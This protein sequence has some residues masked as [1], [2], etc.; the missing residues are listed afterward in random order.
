[1]RALILGGTGYIGSKLAQ[2]LL[3]KNQVS[4]LVICSRSRALIY[5]GVGRL[6]NEVDFESYL[7]DLDGT[8]FSTVFLLHGNSS[9]ESAGGNSIA[10]LASVLGWKNQVS[11]YLKKLGDGVTVVMASTVSVYGTSMDIKCETSPPAPE[12][13]Y[14]L[15]KWFLERHFLLGRYACTFAVA[16]LANVY[17][18]SFGE[19]SSDR[20]VVTK[21]VKKALNESRIEIYGTGKY[22]RDYVHI[23]DVCSA[24][25]KISQLDRAT[26]SEQPIFNVCSGRSRT[27]KEV[28]SLIGHL[29]NDLKSGFSVEI[30]HVF[31]EYGPSVTRQSFV[32]NERLTLLG[33]HP[34]V[35][36]DTGLKEL[37]FACTRMLDD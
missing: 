16:R 8:E 15:N 14:D 4:R 5:D 30:E 33:W 26:I 11:Q 2:S 10:A 20:N 22:H 19:S 25:V 27:I 18:F 32:S 23:D 13:Y 36:F 24:L 3:E 29:V 17:G 35:P 9:L 31:G 12:T 37:I 7:N 21:V 6:S 34:E 28:F 1:M